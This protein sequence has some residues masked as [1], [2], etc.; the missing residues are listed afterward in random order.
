MQR[1]QIFSGLSITHPIFLTNEAWEV[2]LDGTDGVTLHSILFQHRLVSDNTMKGKWWR[3]YSTTSTT[4]SMSCGFPW[5]HNSF[6]GMEHIQLSVFWFYQDL[7]LVYIH[8][9]H[10]CYPN[11]KVCFWDFH[12]IPVHWCFRAVL[13]VLNKKDYETLSVTLMWSR[14]IFVSSV[15]WISE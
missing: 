14:F 8:F 15:Y 13:V 1:M 2:Q 5:L 11:S 3:K 4:E 9:S 12:L 10:E 7:H 6:E